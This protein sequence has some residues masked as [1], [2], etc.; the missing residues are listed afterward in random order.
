MTEPSYDVAIVGGGPV[1]CAAALAFVERGAHVV[2]LEANGGA[3]TRL[4][5]EWL[6]PPAVEI[7][8]RLRV[9]LTA[10]LDHRTGRGFVVFPE[11]G[12]EP[13][14]LGYPD[15]RTGFSLPHARLVE[16]LRAAVAHH[17]IE[18]VDGAR[19]AA[20]SGETVEFRVRG[21]SSSVRAARVVGAWGRAGV[22]RRLFAGSDESIPCSRMAAVIVETELPVEGYGHVFLGGPGPILAYRISPS[23]V[24]LCFDVPFTLPTKVDPRA[25]L[26]DAYGPAV[27]A[28]LRAPLRDA[29]RRRDV[30]WATN[31]T[32]PRHAY[33]RPG[34]ALVGDAVG[35]HHPLTAIGLTL[36]FQDAVA[37][38]GARTFEGYRRGRRVESRIP[39]VLAVSLYDIF[40]GTSDE[41][42]EMR[43]A[44]YALWRGSQTER[45]RTMR[46]LSCDAVGPYDFGT[47]LFKI[48]GRVG[49]DLARESVLDGRRAA[50]TAAEIGKSVKR[51]LHPGARP[52]G[53]VGE[54]EAAR[55][56]DA[57]RRERPRAMTARKEHA[58]RS[59]ALSGTNTEPLN[60]LQMGARALAAEQDEDGSWEGE[61]VWCALLPAEYV[62]AWHVMGRVL[63][64]DRRRRIV[65]QF[66]RTRLPSGLWGLSHVGEPSLFVTALVY[67]AARVLGV[68]ASHDLLKPARAFF[69][70]EPVESIPTWGKFWLALLSLYEWDGVN[71]VVPELWAMPSA[72][73]IHPSRYYCHT[74]LIYVAM[75]VLYAERVRAPVTELT[76]EL[77]SELFP[78]GFDRVDF[79][80]ARTMLRARDLYEA[81]HP[82]LRFGYG[83]F[84]LIDRARSARARKR[85]L[86][87]LREL[88]R[89]ELATTNHTA[90]SP[91]SGLLDILVLGNENPNDADAARAMERFDCWIW[92]DDD[93]GL[94]VAGAR[95]AIWDTSFAVQALGKAAPHVPVGK[96]RLAGA[97]F[98][99]SQQ[100]RT[101]FPDFRKHHR[102]D[103]RGGYPVSWAWHGWPVSDCTAE[104]ILARLETPGDA[105]SDDD[106]ALAAAFI[107]R[108]QADDGGF[109]SYEEKR[110]PFSIEWMNPAEMFGD[111]MAEAGYVE[112]TA[113]CVAALAKIRHE[114][115]H[116]LSR[117]ELRHLPAALASGMRAIRR[118]QLPWGAWPGAWGVRFIYGTWFGIRGLVAGGAP[119]T[120]AAVKKACRWLKSVQRPD[121]GWGE[122]L[123]PRGTAYAPHEDGQ[124]IQTAWAMLA[125]LEASD[126]DFPAVER[127]AHFLSRAQLGNGQWPRQDPQGLFFRTARL[128]YT[129]YRSYFP[130]WALAEFETRRAERE[131]L[132]VGSKSLAA[133]DL[134]A[135]VDHERE[136]HPAEVRRPPSRPDSAAG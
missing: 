99:E 7:L 121:G 50:R 66:E 13:I 75:A 80:A 133:A 106:V 109:G 32:S 105:V 25:A 63:P 113:S 34:F 103:P 124:V 128:E 108:C 98:L 76:H 3:A 49:F 43:R 112:C 41:S 115:P 37:L 71:P 36:G 19:V 11:D 42:V 107:L 39:E 72:M 135:A 38:A 45:D 74:R 132:V 28:N 1:G 29:L 84:R 83:V 8:E 17:A 30:E 102:T 21:S 131:R 126:P 24:R 59:G 127:A 122:R 14:V 2:V 130:L 110:V 94:R 104:A 23:E 48:L 120:D 51:W 54:T 119:P 27:P 22:S 20:V 62:L 70:S 81:P 18:Y 101:A 46:L 123:E 65:L 68:A 64:E 91:V 58:A 16:S 60:A 78:Q 92:E 12:S 117:E 90:I 82:V 67:V 125:L 79:R 57:T 56:S 40:S 9:G 100:I 35:H 89:W 15:G 47:T 33:G 44:I 118:R 4:A 73:P 52:H 111:S 86:G 85:L 88:I 55:L 61:C 69:A 31:A 114:R 129:L 97:K 134:E 116:L 136:R 95:S 10:G 93:D 6:H 77:R 96:G 26:F 5:G 87:E 53:D